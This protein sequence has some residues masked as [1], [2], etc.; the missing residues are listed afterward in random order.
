MTANLGNNPVSIAMTVVNFTDPLLSLTAK[1]ALNLAEVGQF[2]PLEAGTELGGHLTAD[3]HLAGKVKDPAG[4][5]A[6][7]TMTFVNVTAKTATTRNPV[8]DLNGTVS[9]DNQL[10]DSKNLTMNLGKSDLKLSFSL[11]NYL[12]LTL[13]QLQFPP[14]SPSSIT[15]ACC[16][17]KTSAT[18]P[19][20]AVRSHYA[21]DERVDAQLLMKLGFFADHAGQSPPTR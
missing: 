20:E 14:P 4:M 1:G 11:R 8:R 19:I 12:S 3:V 10:I 7:G 16:R 6:A 18:T 5:K 21:C 2:Y 17:K 13:P 9:F 15:V